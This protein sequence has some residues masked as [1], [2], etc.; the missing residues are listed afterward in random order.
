[1]LYAGGVSPPLPAEDKDTPSMGM[2]LFTDED[3]AREFV[4]GDPYVKEG[5]V[6]EYSVREWACV[7]V[8]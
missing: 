6:K 4:Q 3:D 8:P 2:F 1:M 5:V 7:V